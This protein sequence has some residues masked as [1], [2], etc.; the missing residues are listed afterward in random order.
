MRKPLMLLAAGALIAYAATAAQAA[1]QS[2]LK[3]RDWPQ[4]GPFGTFERDSLQRGFQVYKE[5]CAACH[6]LEYLAYRHLEGIGLSEEE[7]EAVAAEATVIDGPNEDGEMFERPGKPSDR[8][9][10]PFPNDAAAKAANNGALPP[11]LSVIVKARK[12]HEDYINSLLTGYGEP[13]AGVEMREGTNYNAHYPG[14]QIAMP[15]PLSEG[16]VTYADGTEATVEQMSYDVTNFL[17]WAAEP[18][19]E[20]RKRMGVKVV[21]FLLLFTGLAYAVKRKVWADLH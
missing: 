2:P 19:L 12:G 3:T 6:S 4:G 8:M 18:T 9:P 17:A 20:A 11:D 10:K 5:V 14:Q 7:I 1:E 16:G 21:L 15:P 13:P